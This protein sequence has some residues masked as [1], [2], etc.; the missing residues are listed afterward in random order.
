MIELLVADRCIACNKCVTICPQDVFDPVPGEAPVIAR[1]EDCHLC[2]T[3]ELF[4]PVDALY[5]SPL[6]DPE[7]DFDPDRVIAAGHLGSYARALGWVKGRAPSGTG[8]DWGQKLREAQ[9]RYDAPDP[10]DRVRMQ[11]R[12]AFGRNYI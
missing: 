10:T 2:N 12:E 8:D 9:G 3:C 4:C 7:P 1:Q 5:V 6:S 11:L